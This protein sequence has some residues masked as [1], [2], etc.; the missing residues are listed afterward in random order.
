[1]GYIWD[2]ILCV[3]QIPLD[4][5]ILCSKHPIISSLASHIILRSVQ[6]LLVLF[7]IQVENVQFVQENIS[8]TYIL[9]KFYYSWLIS[10]LESHGADSL[11]DLHCSAVEG[12]FI[13]REWKAG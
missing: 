3:C 10:L 8:I 9:A 2:P 12:L 5:F 1:M 13:R 7:A 4:S 6:M 11:S